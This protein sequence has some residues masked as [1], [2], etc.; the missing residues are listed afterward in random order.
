MTKDDLAL[1]EQASEDQET[2]VADQE[3]SEADEAME[4]LKEAVNLEREEVGALRLKLKISV[5]REII[6]ERLDKQFQEL[7]RDAVIPGFRKGHAPLRL[8]EKRFAA[9]IGDELKGQL[10]GGSYLAV[11]ERENLTVL[12]DP[13]VWVKVGEER[14]TE[15]GGV[16]KV[17]VEKLLPIDKALEHM[18]L[19]QDGPL[20]FACEVELK[21][22]FELPNLEKIPVVKPKIEIDDGD[23]DAEVRRLCAYRGT[24]EPIEDEPIQVDDLLYVD[25]KMTVEG[26]V[27]LDEKNTD[28]P[29][30]D[31]RIKGI[32]LTGLADALTGKKREEQLS[33]EAA[34]PDDHENL[35][36]RGKKARLEITIREIKRFMVPPVDEEFLSVAG[37]ESE[38]ELRTAVRQ[39]LESRIEQATRDEMHEQVASY[40]IDNTKLEIPEGLSQRQTERSVARRMISM[41]ESGMPQA[42]ID[43]RADEM[44]AKAHDQV[45]RDIKLFFI[46][47][48]I[49]TDR[50]VEVAE[51]Q[52]NGAIA[53]IAQR[54]GKR[55]DR[56][57]DELSKGE[58]LT[59]L[60]VQLR[61]RA[62]IDQLLEEAEITEADRP[63]TKSARLA[64]P[65]R[66]KP[67]QSPPPEKPAAAPR[68]A[69]GP[70]KKKATSTTSGKKKASGATAKKTSKKAGP[71]KTAKK[72]KST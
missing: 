11:T 24:F 44:R 25:L 69:S 49:A 70:A 10:I 8:V 45:I 52:L 71:K 5:P 13:L 57:R 23:V 15:S 27:L 72:K 68:E 42:E 3:R 17:E 41:Y 33:F 14:T 2:A 28:L 67:T 7:R 19:P 61:D 51:E 47:E 48:K 54:S 43:K 18:S 35:D 58:G 56:V 53:A 30:R 50:G 63:K 32:P 1:D 64:P 37:F 60:Y 39:S 21:P 55:F 9:D 26:D 34:V 36:I 66:T 16:R 20:E 38:E 62:V 46:L 22:E 40:L 12:G 65:V 31:V 59:T 4:K 29:A 6:A